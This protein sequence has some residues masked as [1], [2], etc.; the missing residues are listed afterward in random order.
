MRQVRNDD[1]RY[2]GTLARDERGPKYKKVSGASA[3]GKNGY[4][5]LSLDE[6]PGSTTGRKPM[7]REVLPNGMYPSD[8]DFPFD[9]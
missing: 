7:N 1:I 6:N 4:E 3:M 2:E 9:V 5:T 8:L